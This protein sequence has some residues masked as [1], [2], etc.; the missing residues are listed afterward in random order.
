MRDILIKHG[1]FQSHKVPYRYY[2]WAEDDYGKRYLLE[3]VVGD[4]HGLE[5]EMV[6]AITFRQ[7]V[8]FVH[9][10]QYVIR[11]EKELEIALQRAE[12]F[13]HAI[14]DRIY[15]ERHSDGKRNAKSPA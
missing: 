6:S 4:R 5:E 12:A 11:D 14:C 9:L 1:F 8:P 2:K 10:V 13:W 15:Y 3:A 7:N